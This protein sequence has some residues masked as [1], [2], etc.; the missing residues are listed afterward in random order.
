MRF[1]KSV[2][3]FGHEIKV[4]QRADLYEAEGAYGMY[5]PARHL[6]ELQKPGPHFDA[7]FIMQT[8]WH[9][10][11]HAILFHASRPEYSD[12]ALVDLLAQGIYQVHQ[13][14]GTPKPTRTPRRS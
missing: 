1:P 13:G 11:V 10:V 12:E 4:V 7:G 8:L 14:I 5:H 3:L 2:R 9:E 6:I